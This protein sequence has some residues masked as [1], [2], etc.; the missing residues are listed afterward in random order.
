MSEENYKQIDDYFENLKNNPADIYTLYNEN[1][2]DW[3]GPRNKVDQ[4]YTDY[5]AEKLIKTGNLFSEISLKSDRGNYLTPDHDGTIDKFT[6]RSEEIFAK[7]LLHHQIAHLG[8]IIDYQ[9]PLKEVRAD[10][11]GKIDLV[12]FNADSNTSYLIELKVASD[13]TILRAALEVETYSQLIGNDT[14]QE[15]V[16]KKAKKYFEK[17][18]YDQINFDR[19]KI[20]KAIVFVIEDILDSPNEISKRDRNTHPHLKKLLTDYRIEPYL[21]ERQYPTRSM[22]GLF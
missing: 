9:V 13:E 5:I 15:Y 7:M 12:S 6:N 2:V 14:F 11:F 22:L 19:T 3:S 21:L 18:K 16:K 1:F 4:P 17:D 20:K 8:R 10:N